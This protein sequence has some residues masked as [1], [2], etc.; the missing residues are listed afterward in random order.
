M[1]IFATAVLA[2][3]LVASA[4]AS[5]LTDPNGATKF[6]QIPGGGVQITNLSNTTQNVRF[7]QPGVEINLTL[8]AGDVQTVGTSTQGFYEWTCAA[9]YVAVIPGTSTLPTYANHDTQVNCR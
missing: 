8:N 3:A 9:P 4:F 1:K 7:V 6:Y 5:T 2:L